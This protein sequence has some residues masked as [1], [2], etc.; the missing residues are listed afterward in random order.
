MTTI[1]SRKSVPNTHRILIEDV[2]PTLTEFSHITDIPM[3]DIHLLGSANKSDT[4]GDIDIALD[5]KIYNLDDTHWMIQRLPCITPEH[6]SI[7]AGLGVCSYSF[8]IRS[9]S[10]FSQYKNVQLDIMFTPDVNWAQFSY[11]SAVHNTEYKGAVRVILLIA[12]AAAIDIDGIDYFQ[13]DDD[14]NLLA[15]GGRV[16]DMNVGLRRIFQHRPMRKDGKGYTKTLKS[17]QSDDFIDLFPKASINRNQMI[18]S[19]PTEALTIMFESV[20]TPS[21]VETAEQVLKLIQTKFSTEKQNKIFD[22]ARKRASSV[23]DKMMLPTELI[24]ET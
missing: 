24:D 7:N 9:E 17:I 10:A 11:F 18:I 21:E 19:D 14:G 1:L 22:I 6:S 23:K 12:V 13:Y 16:F 3:S 8:P 2:I 15:R 4:S 5:R 20:V